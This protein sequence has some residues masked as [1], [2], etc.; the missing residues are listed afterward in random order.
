MT[1]L[2]ITNARLL[3]LHEVIARG[4]LLCRDGKIAAFGAGD[5]PDFESVT[6]LDANGATLLP[7]FIDLHVHGAMGHDVM[8]ADAG[9]LRAMARF[10]ALHGVTAFL[11]TTL[12][13]SQAAITA[14]LRTIQTA[15]QHPADSWGGAAILGAHLEG[16]YLNLSKSGAQQTEYI[17]P[18]D[19]DEA[20]AWLDLDVIRLLAI[21]PEFEA[22]H[23]LIVECVRR[24][25]TV[26]AAHTDA[27]FEQMQHGISLGITQA[28]H[29]Y[30]AMRGL[31]HRDPGTLGAVLDSA[32]V[33]CELVTDN[34]HVHPGAQ[35]L[36]WKLK[37]TDGVMLITDAMRATGMGEGDYTLGD[38]RVIVADGMAALENGTLAGSI[39]TF[40]RGVVNFMAATGEPLERVWR[41]TSYNAACA[42]GADDR[43]GSITVGKDADVVL[44][45]AQINVL[46]TVCMGK[47]IPLTR[48]AAT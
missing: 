40:E 6:P 26:S 30:N 15:M 48:A 31:H 37:G 41:A 35:R 45:D 38:Y 20:R 19:M 2:L 3:T 12:T 9:G 4:W 46:L 13:G 28:T 42:I 39:I 11:P 7:G 47:I 29:T 17:R 22:N 33:R 36:L 23:A 34:I 44:V 8:D 5:T 18:V 43:K 14:A 25:V 27:T 24:G 21:A 10:F 16:P 32:A 1:D